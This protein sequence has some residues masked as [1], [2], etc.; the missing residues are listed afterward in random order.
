MIK[1]IISI[2]VKIII[3]FSLVS[4]ITL[5]SG[6]AII[7]IIFVLIS[8]IVTTTTNNYND[9]EN[10]NY[11]TIR[12]QDEASDVHLVVYADGASIVDNLDKLFHYNYC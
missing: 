9:Y 8:M 11:D 12:F 1:I 3:I 5:N 6:S 7:R 4:W 2:I 10:K